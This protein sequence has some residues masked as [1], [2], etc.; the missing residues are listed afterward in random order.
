[1]DVALIPELVHRDGDKV[2]APP[3]PALSRP[4]RRRSTRDQIRHIWGAI[5]LGG[6]F[7]KRSFIHLFFMEKN[8]NHEPSSSP[9]N[10]LLTF[11]AGAAVGGVVV[12]LT[13]PK[14]GSDLR[15]DLSRFAGKAKDHVHDWADSASGAVEGM[16]ATG[17]GSGKAEEMAGKAQDAWKDVKKTA[18]NAGSELKEGLTAAG[19]ELRT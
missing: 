14:R 1:M 17:Q 11:L 3:G 2:R 8:M 10:T 9:G 13:T 7:L 6:P 16:T 12:A 4:V 15:K 18:S 5:R 19:R